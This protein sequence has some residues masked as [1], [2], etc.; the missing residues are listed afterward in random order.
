M[1]RAT[2]TSWNMLYRLTAIERNSHIAQ[3]R[4]ILATAMTK[5][6]VSDTHALVLP[7]HL[8]ASSK[9]CWD[10]KESN[11]CISSTRTSSA[12]PSRTA[13]VAKD[14]TW[15]NNV[16]RL[17]V[18]LWKEPEPSLPAITSEAPSFASL[19]VIVGRPKLRKDGRACR[20]LS[21]ESNRSRSS[22]RTAWLIIFCLSAEWAW[23]WSAF[24][25]STLEL[26]HCSWKLFEE[27]VP[28]SGAGT[29][30]YRQPPSLLRFWLLGKSRLQ[31][32]Q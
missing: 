20:D 16:W 10:G 24:I 22:S 7:I 31:S 13:S 6:A 4:R 23:Q 9:T 18:C 5:L 11:F 15:E 2:F 17:L 1:T 32:L 14:S 19:E 27:L 8:K 30:A 28:S 26:T 25:S 3:Y 12:S 21:R 29:K